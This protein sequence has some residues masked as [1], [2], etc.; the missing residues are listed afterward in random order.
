M[1]HAVALHFIAYNFYRPHGTLT[2][3]KGGIHTTPAMA[4]GVT[5]HVRTVDD[6]VALLDPS[7]M[8]E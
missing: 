6:L 7:H 4:A 3:A 2:K 1:G 8:V 5:D